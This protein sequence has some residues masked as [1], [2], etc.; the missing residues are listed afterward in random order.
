MSKARTKR[1]AVKVSIEEH[2]IIVNNAKANNKSISL[3]VREKAML[4][5]TAKNNK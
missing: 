3:F 1:L 4:G 2:A 5:K